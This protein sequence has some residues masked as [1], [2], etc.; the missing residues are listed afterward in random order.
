MKKSGQWFIRWIVLSMILDAGW[1]V[2]FGWVEFVASNWWKGST[3]AALVI[4]V[5][6]AVAIRSAGADQAN[7]VE[8]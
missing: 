7:I 4:L 5:W 3:M 8:L 2:M 1:V 6:A